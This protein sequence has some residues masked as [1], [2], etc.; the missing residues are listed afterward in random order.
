ML[1]VHIPSWF[2]NAESPLSGNFILRQIATVGD[3]TTSVILHHADPDLDI[4]IPENV[5]F[6]PVPNVKKWKL[7]EAYMKAF[8]QIMREY[9]RPD[10]LHLHVAWPLGPLAAYIAR[11]YGIPMV[12]SEHWSGYQPMNRGRLT[13]IQK[14]ALNY[15]FSTASHITAVSQNLLD[16]ICATIPDAAQKRQSVVGNVVDTGL[17]SLKQPT[18]NDKKRILHVST[19]DDDAKNI[20]GILRAIKSLSSQRTDFELHIVHDLENKE[21]ESFV[22]ENGLSGVVHFLGR[23]SSAEIADLFHQS[24]FFLL[25]SNYENQP[26][27]LLES[28]CTGTPVV[29]TPVGGIPEIANAGNS[30][31][32]APKDE[33]QLIEK[34]EFMLDNAHKFNPM[35]IREKALQIC[36]TEVIREKW[37]EIYRSL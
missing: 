3:S 30:V 25:F 27:V 21:A 10:I 31:I 24:D 8:A 35:E 34:L 9:G 28:F 19:L 13:F 14:R 33:T 23:K 15:T 18:Q 17:F 4:P 26:C 29:T 16:N 37:L 11:K 1:I 32:V 5:H 6:H 20:T 12:I 2:P 22:E 36:S 7:P